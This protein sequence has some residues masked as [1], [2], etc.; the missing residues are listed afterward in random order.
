M[1]KKNAWFS[2][3]IRL[4]TALLLVSCTPVDNIEE[5]LAEEEEAM[6]EN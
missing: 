5:E 2:L 6:P 1:N 3:S 4:L